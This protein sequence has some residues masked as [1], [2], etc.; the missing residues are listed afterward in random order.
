MPCRRAG[1]LL[2]L[3]FVPA[4]ALAQARAP[5]FVP[6]TSAATRREVM[7]AELAKVAVAQASHFA[8]HKQYADN[9]TPT[10]ASTTSAM[11]LRITN[12][13]PT[14]WAAVA[15]SLADTSLHCGIYEGSAS[16]PNAAVTRPRTPRCWG[17]L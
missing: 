3:A 14:G 8:R 16:P 5:L 1:F 6:D 2:S 17:G 13:S 11:V 12:V 9:M 15:T 10:R 7:K 4:S